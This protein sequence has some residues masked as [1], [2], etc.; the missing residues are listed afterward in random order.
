MKV[1]D[2]GVL[3]KPLNHARFQLITSDPS[4]ELTI[5]DVHLSDSALYYCD[6]NSSPVYKTKNVVKKP[7][8]LFTLNLTSNHF[9]L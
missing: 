3:Q 4:T 5:T 9:N 2:H 8:G 1:L 7:E 6:I